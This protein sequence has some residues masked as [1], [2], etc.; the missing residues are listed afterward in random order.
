MYNHLEIEKWRK[1]Q[2]YERTKN[3]RP[4]LLKLKK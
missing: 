2:S 4:D 1:Q 3:R